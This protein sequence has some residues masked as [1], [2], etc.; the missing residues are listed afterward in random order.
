MTGQAPR[1]EAAARGLMVTLAHDASGNTL[2]MMAMFLIPL[3]GLVGSTVDMGRIYVAK[4]R[5]QQACDAG[6]LAGRKTMAYTNNTA[7]DDNAVTQA[8]AF[9]ANNFNKDDPT[10]TPAVTGYMG[11]TKVAFTPTKTTDNQV[12]ATATATVPM[13]V[14][15][16][17]GTK[18]VTLTVTCEARFDVADTDVMFVLDTTGSMACLASQTAGCSPTI[19]SY[20][21]PDGTTGYYAQEVSGSKLSGVRTAVL[22]FYDTVA[23]SKDDTTHIRYGFVTY[24]STVNAG[25]AVTQV[26]PVDPTVTDITNYPLYMVRNWSYD[27]RRLKGDMNDGTSSNVSK[28]NMTSAAC[29][30]LVRDP[31]TGY[32]TDGTATVYTYQSWTQTSTSGSPALGTCKL[33]AQPVKPAWIYDYSQLDVGNYVMGN[34]VD[35]PS[36]ITAATSRWQG[37][38]EERDTTTGATSFDQTKLPP[39]LDPDLIPNGSTATKWRPMWPD[40]IYYRGTATSLDSSVLD[41]GNNKNWAGTN[42]TNPRGDSNS[43]TQTGVWTALNLYQNISSG[44]VSCGKPVQRLDTLTRAQV[45]AYVNASDFVPQGGTYHDTGMIWGTRMISPNGIFKNDTSTWPGRNAPNRYIVFM[46]DGDMAPNANIYGLYGIEAYRKRVAN[47]NQGNLTTYTN[48]HNQRFLAECAAA[49]A[50]NIKVFV[51]GFG[52]QL[53]NE[54]TTCASD[55][56]AYYASDNKSLDTAFQKIAKQVA[57]LRV[58][59]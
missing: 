59:K 24:T 48:Y 25:Y 15:K 40:V 8:N 57:M 20:T 36:K 54:L 43:T 13:T 1:T 2:A 26:S 32:A 7:L 33:S 49:K 4:T 37:C 19:K 41:N 55:G 3:T 44:Y 51:V 16:I 27:T 31:A 6:A 53:T 39:D 35:D 23:A 47:G 42:S 17:I 28:L 58:T 10:K 46:T 5:L 34:S 52:Q 11:T 12:A 38:L 22:N 21:R 56:Q 29:T 50:R 30:A 14:S 45:S 18:D 9:F